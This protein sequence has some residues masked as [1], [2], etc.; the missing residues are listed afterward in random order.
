MKTLLIS[1]ELLEAMY[2]EARRAY[3]DEACGLVVGK[4]GANRRA[5]SFIPTKNIQ[6]DL[7][8]RDPV[9]YSRT[10]TTAYSIDPR[11]YQ[12]VA[13]EA[14][15]NG[16]EI[17]AVFHSHPEHGV[18][19]SDEDKG[20]AAPWGEPLFPALSYVVVSV[21]GGEVKNS[22]EFYWSDEAKDFLECK[23]K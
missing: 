7:H 12:R 4:V 10:A 14:V 21:Y 16:C 6:N 20:M 3:P 23:I 19:F 9:R 11:E 15:K 8:Q 5:V 2:T 18:Y 13:D 1:P 17:V 22:S